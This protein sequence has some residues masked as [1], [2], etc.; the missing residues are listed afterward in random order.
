MLLDS[1]KEVII[2]I[3]PKL[4][5]D[6][7]VVSS[8]C[9]LSMLNVDL[10]ILSKVLASR[11]LGY[12]PQLIADDQ[13]G[14]IPNRNTQCNLRLLSLIL[15]STA[16]Y[17]GQYSLALLDIEQA[18]DSLSWEFCWEVL[19]KMNI[20]GRYNKWVQLLYKEPSASVRIGGLVS[21]S[22]PLRRGT[23]QRCPLSL[24]L[25]AIA[26]Q[27]LASHLREVLH[28]WGVQF[29]DTRHVVSLYA[30]DALGISSEP[31]SIGL[32][33]TGGPGGV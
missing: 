30:D 6:S 25:F 9:Q 14:F 33:H 4:D 12:L 11:L 8:Y 29:G 10:N 17:E 15:H 24:I 27:P 13:C 7:Q 19:Y 3:L 26:M 5:R 1:L 16:L 22:F 32:G 21:Q 20:R 31:E 2:V 28:E 23:R 18:F